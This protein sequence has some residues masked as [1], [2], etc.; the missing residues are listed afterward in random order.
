[1]NKN[2]SNTIIS[3][4]NEA[5]K[6]LMIYPNTMMATLIP[7]GYSQLA[8]CMVEAGF[9]VEIFDTTFYE[10]EKIASQ[11]KKAQYLQN[12]NFKY[13]FEL[14]DPEFMYSDLVQKIEDYKPGLICVTIVAGMKKM[15]YDLLESIKD[16]R[17]PVIAGGV[18]VTLI[19]EEILENENIDF[20]CVGEG[21]KALVELCQKLSAG[22]DCSTIQN[23]WVKQ[24]GQIT[25]N[26]L[27]NLV[28]LENLPLP[29]LSLWDSRRFK[30]AMYGRIYNMIHVVTDRGCPYSCTYCASPT[31]KKFIQDCDIGHYF[32]QKSTEGIFKDLRELVKRWDPGYI[33]FN[34]EN[35]L[36]RPIEQFRDFAKQY[37]E[38]FGIP[39]WMNTRSETIT[40]E[41]AK[42]LKEMNCHCT[43]LGLESGNYELRKSI[44]HRLEDNDTIIE[45]IR[46]LDKF[47]IRYVVN[48]VIGFPEE[49]RDMIF[50]TIELNRNLNSVTTNCF[51]FV[52]MEGT[53]IRKYCIDHGYIDDTMGLDAQLMFGC[54]LKKSK[55]SWDELNGLH[56]TFV[57]YVYFPREEWPKIKIAEKFDDE[58]DAMFERLRT[59]FYDRGYFDRD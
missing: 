33:I 14:R 35:F 56:R 40:D 6:V 20:I 16:Y 39:F 43:Q 57:M 30:R 49:S 25:K 12:K 52:P 48:N 18:L 31:L 22:D 54:P 5:F 34:S 45:K 53:P 50:E 7:I 11:F 42:L 2:G 1:M 24:D 41:K 3:T 58:G 37:A 28:D 36:M 21:E 10:T 8:T 27:R 15:A 19:P 44:L 23:L 4:N 46:I 55:I 59:E 51:L 38:E 29:D 13:E 26:P 9:K 32:R 47:G 17:I